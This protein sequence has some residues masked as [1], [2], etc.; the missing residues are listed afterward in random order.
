MRIKQGSR[1]LSSPFTD[2]SETNLDMTLSECAMKTDNS[3][4]SQ[5][6]TSN[7]SILNQTSS[8][9]IPLISI[10]STQDDPMDAHQ[11]R[12]WRKTILRSRYSKGDIYRS[13]QRK[14]TLT[15]NEVDSEFLR[16]RGQLLCPVKSEDDMMIVLPTTKRS[17]HQQMQHTSHRRTVQTA[18]VSLFFGRQDGQT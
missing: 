10:Q 11:R 12:L 8:C 18:Q 13:T 6:S 17:S 15:V 3:N 16:F 5:S 7:T 4:I 2:T 14:R 9:T 1:V